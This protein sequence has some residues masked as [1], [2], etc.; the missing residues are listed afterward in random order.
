MDLKK[1]LG[2]I[3]CNALSVAV[4]PFGNMA[5]NVLRDVL[6]LEDDA[7]D[8]DILKAVE[9]ASPEQVLALKKAD[10]DFKLKMKEMEV[11]IIKLDKDDK[12]DARGFAERVG[13][14]TVNSLAIANTL[15]VSVTISGIGY[16]VY[17]EKLAGMDALTASLLTI[18]IRE[19]FAK[20]EQIYNFFFGSSHGSKSKDESL[21]KKN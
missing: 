9:S 5:A 21:N 16:L 19:V 12:K 8:N 1:I 18:A 11:D 7:S 2:N 3:G 15:L 17:S 13:I 4:P 14:K 10:N 6:D 20:Q